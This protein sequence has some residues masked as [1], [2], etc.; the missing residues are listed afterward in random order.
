MLGDETYP[1]PS[2]AGFHDW[3]FGKNGIPHPA[4]CPKCGRKTNPNYINP[5]FRARKRKWD[6]SGTYD[7]YT[8][9][10]K[11]FRDFCKRS[12]WKGMNFV[13]LPADKGFFVLRLLLILAFDAKRRKTRFDDPCPACGAFYNVIGS[14]PAFLAGIKQPIMDGF[15]RSDLEFASGPEQA[16][17]I[18]VGIETAEKLRKQNFQKFALEEVVA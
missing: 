10:S 16:P 15:Y 17:L 4:T 12:K 2:S 13:P 18:F 14:D 11:R 3:R 6:M 1:S 9:V 7:G 8:I 5:K